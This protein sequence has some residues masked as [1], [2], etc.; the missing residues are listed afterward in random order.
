M[1]KQSL[2]GVRVLHTL[3]A[4]L[5]HSLSYELEQMP[6]KAGMADVHVAE[7]RD[8]VWYS[9]RIFPLARLAQT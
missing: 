5:Q 3:Y 2:Y 1:P 7:C 4:I 6:R 8:S 9:T